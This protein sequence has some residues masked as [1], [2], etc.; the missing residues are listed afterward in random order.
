MTRAQA[1]S[2][3]PGRRPND[4]QIDEIVMTVGVEGVRLRWA[5]EIEAEWVRYLVENNPSFLRE[6]SNRP[7]SSCP[8]R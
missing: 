6:T 5:D 4:F 1:V 3:G 8:E 2:A 7:V